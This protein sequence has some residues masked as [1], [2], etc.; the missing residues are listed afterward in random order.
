MEVRLSSPG[1]QLDEGDKDRIRKDLDKIARRLNEF[2][3]VTANVRV[4]GN[5]EGGQ[6]YDIVLEVA[7]GRKHLMA[8]TNH[9]D[10]G[11]GVRT[12]R[13]EIL[14]QIND[15]SRGGHSSFTKS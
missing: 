11:Q 1:T 3:E 7:Y 12:A 6:G 14:R 15:R 10:V 8:K 4:N 2:S 5:G 9:R 13:E